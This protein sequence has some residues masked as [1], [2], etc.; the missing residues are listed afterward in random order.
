MVLRAESFLFCPLRRFPHCSDAHGVSASAEHSTASSTA[1]AASTLCVD[2]E[3]RGGAL[4]DAASEL[5]TLRGYGGGREEVS[6][7]KGLRTQA[8]AQASTAA[9][10]ERVR[11]RLAAAALRLDRDERELAGRIARR[12]RIAGRL[13][14]PRGRPAKA[15]GLLAASHGC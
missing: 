5:P 2:D 14:Q 9:G 11:V 13:L 8:S 15:G 10:F 1:A 4:L 3:Q 12:A 7:R 6:A